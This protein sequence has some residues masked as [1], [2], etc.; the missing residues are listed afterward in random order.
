MKNKFRETAGNFIID[1]IG[2]NEKT[3]KLGL[4]ELLKK[5]ARDAMEE[6]A[7]IADRHGKIIGECCWNHENS[8]EGE[9]SC[10]EQ[11]SKRIRAAKEAL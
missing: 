11:I 7:V 10:W 5:I 4:E 1:S 2:M 3:V 6:S 8:E 9:S